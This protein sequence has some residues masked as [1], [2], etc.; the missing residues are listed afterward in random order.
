MGSNITFFKIFQSFVVICIKREKHN[1][2]EKGSNVDP[3]D[4]GWQLS[5]HILNRNLTSE[6]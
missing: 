6:D 3:R 5:Y 1:F 2:T 4:N